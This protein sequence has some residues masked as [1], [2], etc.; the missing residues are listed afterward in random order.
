MRLA[1][2]CLASFGGRVCARDGHRDAVLLALSTRAGARRRGDWGQTA[3]RSGWQGAVNYTNH[4]LVCSL[5]SPSTACLPAAESRLP[6]EI[7]RRG[8]PILCSLRLP[9][10]CSGWPPSR[11]GASIAV[12]NSAGHPSARSKATRVRTT[13]PRAALVFRARHAPRLL[14]RLLEGHRR[15]ENRAPHHKGCAW[16]LFQLA[17]QRHTQPAAPLPG[18]YVVLPHRTLEIS[19]PSLEGFT[20]RAPQQGPARSHMAQPMRPPPSVQLT[21]Y[22]PYSAPHV[23]APP[24]SVADVLASAEAAEAVPEES[25]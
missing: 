18:R 9:A 1:L 20:V 2:L 11:P 7:E 24:H 17:F 25:R 12:G 22:V 15:Q 14:R 13:P 5:T 3:V 4:A 19:A 6:A 23:T 8:L 10:R 16:P 21:P